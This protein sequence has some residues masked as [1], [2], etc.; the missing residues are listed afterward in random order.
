[1][2]EKVA[3][4]YMEDVLFARD[5]VIADAVKKLESYTP[6]FEAIAFRGMSGAIIAPEIAG[7]LRKKV[8]L[9][10]KKEIRDHQSHSSRMV[11]GWLGGMRYIIVDDLINSGN[12]VKTIQDEIR[13][14]ETDENFPP[15]ECVGIYLTREVTFYARGGGEYQWAFRD[16]SAVVAAPTPPVG[17]A[18][19][20]ME[21]SVI[22][23]AATCDPISP[24][25]L[26]F[27]CPTLATI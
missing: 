6:G 27:D 24:K 12:T 7:K 26:T 21:C 14:V 1:M 22:V 11:E 19:A 18:R 16:F 9:V 10:R 8:I 25:L 20:A 13:K 15:S 2:S 17:P 4:G 5:E 3:T 23:N